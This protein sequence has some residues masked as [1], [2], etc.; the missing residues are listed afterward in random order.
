MDYKRLAAVNDSLKRVKIHG[1]DYIDTAS[2]VQGFWQLYPNG[3]ITT[4]WLVM[5]TGW[6]VCQ[7]S[8]WSDD[9]C[10]IAQGTAYEHYGSSNINNTSYIENCETSAIG[11]ALG[12]A[13][14]GSTDSI[15]S[16][17]EVLTAITQQEALKAAQD[18]AK[19][20][21]AKNYSNPT[22]VWAEIQ[23]RPDFQNTETFWQFVC[24]EYGGAND[25]L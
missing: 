16:A 13:G 12:N 4:E 20:V 10:I 7:A 24:K 22:T 21:I 6:C 14:I 23:K 19:A 17:D 15:A 18:R 3:K 9:E 2:R 5:E 8:C 11:R 1:R 25:A